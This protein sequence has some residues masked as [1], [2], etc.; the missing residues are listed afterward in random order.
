VHQDVEQ[1]LPR[2]QHVVTALQ[3]KR[4]RLVRHILIQIRDELLGFRA[5]PT[6]RSRTAAHVT[7]AQAVLVSSGVRQP[8]EVAALDEE[9]AIDERA[10]RGVA[11]VRLPVA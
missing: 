1:Q 3:G 6:R 4:A 9:D 11:P 8:L 7:A 5:S 10:D 2:R